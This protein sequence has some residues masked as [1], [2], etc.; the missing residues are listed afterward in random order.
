MDVGWREVDLRAGTSRKDLY[1][2]RQNKAA[3]S[4][5]GGETW[6]ER[7]LPFWGGWL[8]GSGSDGLYAVSHSGGLCHSTDAARTWDPV[9][10]PLDPRISITSLARRGDGLFA[11]GAAANIRDDQR[12]ILLRSNDDG[13]NWATARLL[14]YGMSFLAPTASGLVISGWDSKL[15]HLQP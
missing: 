12:Y 5:D 14:P 4:S 7:S 3:C 15:L 2:T 9:S 6:E 10:L 8:W 13:A 11:I 1:V